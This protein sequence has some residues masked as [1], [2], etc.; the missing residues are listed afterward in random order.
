MDKTLG[1]I[2]V[3]LRVFPNIRCSLKQ[4]ARKLVLEKGVMR[5]FT[6]KLQRPKP[7]APCTIWKVI[8][9][10]MQPALLPHSLKTVDD[11]AINAADVLRLFRRYPKYVEDL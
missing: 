9:Q 3:A 10:P 5:D 8:G 11:L 6:L 4:L 7:I 2:F 1:G